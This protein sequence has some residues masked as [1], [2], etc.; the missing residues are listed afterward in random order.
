MTDV[1]SILKFLHV[2]SAIVWVGGGVMLQILLA[3]TRRAG[4]EALGHLNNSAEWTSTRIFIPVAFA[5]LGTG[6]AT[7]IAGGY[8][9]GA[10]WIN[11]G[12]VGFLSSAVIGMAVI[13]PTSKKMKVLID[14]RG[15]TDPGVEPLVRRINAFGLVDLSVLLV[16]V[17][18]MV[19]K[20]A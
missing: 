2:V 19:V 10:L 1:T 8:D 9:W 18:F 20:P 4:P 12:F 7:V 11:I 14:E 5:A 6:I 3:R 16:V 15:P 13:G 17:F